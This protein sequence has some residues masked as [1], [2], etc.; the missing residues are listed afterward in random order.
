[1]VDSGFS[2][3][4]LPNLITTIRND[5]LTR[6]QSDVVLRRLDAEVYSRVMAAAVHSLY[7][8]LDYL[9]RNMLPDLADEPWLIR[10]GNIK[11]V[12][13][14]QPTAAAGFARWENVSTVVT[15][16]AGTELQ[17]DSQM[18]YTTTET[19]TRGDDGI[20]RAPI[21]AVENGAAGNLDDGTALRLMTPVSGLS[22]TGYADTVEGGTDLEDLEDWR[23]RIMARWYYTPQ[24]GADS[25]YKIW[26]TDVAGITRAWVF[27]HYEGVR[28]TVGVMP[29]NSD[30]DNPIPDATLIA[31]VKEHILPLAPIAGSGLFV[32]PPESLVIDLGIALA[33][34]TPAIRDAVTKEVKSALL[35]DGEPGG[36]IYLSRVSAAISLAT[37]QI[38]HRLDSPGSDIQLGPY[39][40]PILGTITWGNYDIP[41]QKGGLMSDNQYQDISEAR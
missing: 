22:S 39:Q 7:G 16:P 33:K 9:A 24:G 36:K 35:R 21:E 10:H 2:R 27:R 12:P 14:K 5:L 40:L 34:D 25:D 19:V 17:N 31:A 26:A 38:A 37:G 3:P 4:D 30:P 29:A 41:E 8:Y 28:G 13:R 32:F 11:Q 1:M 20:L 23:S 15:L 6:F 18:L